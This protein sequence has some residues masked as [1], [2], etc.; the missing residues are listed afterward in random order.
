MGAVVAGALEPT[1]ER[2][3][4]VKILILG[5]T[6]FVGRHLVAEALNR[7]HQVTLFNRGH[8]NRDLFPQAE[9]LIGDRDG[10]LDALLGRKWDVAVDVSGY[11]P[12]IVRASAELLRD[13]VA[14]YLFVTTGSVYDASKMVTG[15]ESS[16]LVAPPSPPTEEWNG[17]AYGGLKVLCEDVVREVFP[18]RHLMMRLGIVAGPYDHTDR[19]TYWVTRAARGGEMLAVGAPSRPVQFIDARDLAAFAVHGA[20]AGTTGTFNVVRDP[21]PWQALLDAARTVSGS[22]ARYTW[23]NDLKFLQDNVDMRSLP[24]GVVPMALPPELDAMFKRDNARARAAGLTL[25]SLEETARDILAWDR[26][27]PAGDP[28]AAGL[29]PEQERELLRKWHARG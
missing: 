10:G 11:V 23:I 13:S 7:G 19:V 24:F 2:T 29:T 20:E 12:R 25:R 8:T 27:R 3:T 14:R 16:P 28:R 9:K 1:C 5:G 17:P 22:D 21:A 15:D 6:Q 4:P 18:G 26:S